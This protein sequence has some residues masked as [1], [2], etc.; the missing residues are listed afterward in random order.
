M[1]EIEV[2]CN[3]NKTD[4]PKE[5]VKHHPPPGNYKDQI[6]DILQLIVKHFCQLTDTFQTIEEE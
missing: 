1:D 6:K 3:T 2:E 5:K 4:N